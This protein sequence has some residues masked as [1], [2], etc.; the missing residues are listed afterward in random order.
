MRLNL[1]TL[2][3][4]TPA[5]AV[6]LALTMFA[7]GRPVFA[8]EQQAAQPPTQPPVQQPVAAP[9][10]NEPTGPQLQ[11]TADEAVKFALECDYYAED[12]TCMD[13]GHVQ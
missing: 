12:A 1:K 6:V 2:V 3:L 13:H 8:S 11:I 4:R 5:V 10:Q 9:A 7:S